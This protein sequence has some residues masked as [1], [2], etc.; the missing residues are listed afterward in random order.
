MVS[1]YVDDILASGP[2]ANFEDLL[3]LGGIIR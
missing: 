2:A 1:V 3:A